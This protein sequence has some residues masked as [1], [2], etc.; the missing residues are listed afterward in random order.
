MSELDG[1]KAEFN[2]VLE[3]L[4]LRCR[5]CKYGQFAIGLAWAFDESTGAFWPT[6]ED[7]RE[8][9]GEEECDVAGSTNPGAEIINEHA[10]L[11]F[12]PLPDANRDTCPYR[13]AS[14]S[15]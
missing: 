14:S 4:P 12:L 2:E 6:V 9:C 13:K 8:I 11:L 7:M 5:T 15:Q 1:A 3:L 10:P